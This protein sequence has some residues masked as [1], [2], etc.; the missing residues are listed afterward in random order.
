MNIFKGIVILPLVVL[1]ITAGCTSGQNVREGESPDLNKASAVFTEESLP[2]PP[3]DTSEEQDIRS[4]MVGDWKIQTG[5]QEVFFWQ[6]HNDGTLT[7]GSEPQSHRIKGTLSSFGFDKY[8]VIQASDS[9]GNGTQITYDM[10]I[11]SDPTN[12]TISVDNPVEK[13]NWKFTRQV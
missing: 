6:F 1:L 13:I 4:L 11:T 10:A 5:D 9:T 3:A 12:G 8:I 2:I 7:G